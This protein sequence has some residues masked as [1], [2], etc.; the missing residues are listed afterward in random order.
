MYE[1]ATSEIAQEIAEAGKEAVDELGIVDLP[2]KL[3][4]I[5]GRLK[6]RT[7]Y[8]QNMLKHSIEMAKLAGLLARENIFRLI[9]PSY[10]VSTNTKSR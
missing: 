9:Q 7:S 6:F 4:R 1:K 10:V 3:I 8:G 2:P 5:L